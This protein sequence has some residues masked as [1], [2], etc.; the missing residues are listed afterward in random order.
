MRFNRFLQLLVPFV[1]SVLASLHAHGAIDATLGPSAPVVQGSAVEECLPGSEALA[2]ETKLRE[3]FSMLEIEIARRALLET[4]E[5][6]G[7][8]RRRLES[9]GAEEVADLTAVARAKIFE[10]RIALSDGKMANVVGTRGRLT[11][12]IDDAGNEAYSMPQTI[13]VLDFLR[14][15]AYGAETGATSENTELWPVLIPGFVIGTGCALQREHCTY[16]CNRICRCGV[17]SL[18]MSLCGGSCKCQCASCP[19]P[20]R[21]PWPLAGG[22]TGPFF[23]DAVPWDFGRGAPWIVGPADPFDWLTP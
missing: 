22:P 8:F 2:V 7:A 21:F 23:P 17:Q 14:I 11:Y 15:Q 19:Q 18:D 16:S 10:A 12:A 3:R 13:D 5:R 4:S 20:P 9:K 1:V 6:H